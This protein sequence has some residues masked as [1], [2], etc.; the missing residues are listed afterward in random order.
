MIT[1]WLYHRLDMGTFMLCTN[2]K[3]CINIMY[4]RLCVYI[5]L[6]VPMYRTNQRPCLLNAAS[7]IQMMVVKRW[8]N[9]LDIVTANMRWISFYNFSSVLRTRYSRVVRCFGHCASQR[10][11]QLITLHLI[12]FFD[13]CWYF[14]WLH[15][16][17]QRN[18]LPFLFFFLPSK[19]PEISSP[20]LSDHSFLLY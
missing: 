9:E 14:L 11:Q 8:N 3:K 15:K 18:E 16:N 12:G 7:W 2:F 5:Y 6:L 4:V 19:P 13:S 20:S 1:I 10:W 17:T